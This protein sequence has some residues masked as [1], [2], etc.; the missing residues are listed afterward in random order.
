MYTLYGDQTSCCASDVFWFRLVSK[1]TELTPPPR[2]KI[3]CGDINPYVLQ[4]LCAQVTIIGPL[5]GS[6]GV[7]SFGVG[8]N[9]LGR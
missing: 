4:D 5:D 7:V 8:F 6:T 1:G 9:V 2:D 3:H